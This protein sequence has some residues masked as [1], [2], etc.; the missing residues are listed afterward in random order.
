MNQSVFVTGEPS[1][2]LRKLLSFH[3]KQKSFFKKYSQLK[4]PKE[5]KQ[6]QDSPEDLEKK[7]LQTL[8]D[9]KQE[10]RKIFTLIAQNMKRKN[11]K[12]AKREKE[13]LSLYLKV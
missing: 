8:E 2:S 9:L 1:E 11:E 5:L 3:I 4:K 10:K 6:L 7:I 13:K 12:K